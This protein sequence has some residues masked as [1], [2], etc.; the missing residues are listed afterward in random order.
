[1]FVGAMI[2][3]LFSWMGVIDGLIKLFGGTV[4]AS[5][6]SGVFFTSA[7]TI[8]PASVAL[9]RIAFLADPW[10][11][12]LWGALGAM[13]GDLILFYF[14]RDRFVDDLAASVKP[15]VKKHILSSFHLGFMKWLAPLAGAVIIF[16]PLPDEMGLALMGLSKTRVAVLMPI[17]FTMNLFAIYGI[18]WL[19]HTI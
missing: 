10:T 5:F 13:C 19:A 7:F 6:V 3:L 1:M 14:I 9:S 8:A 2:A 16:S 4:I 15:S 12:A 18:V 17:S 11:I